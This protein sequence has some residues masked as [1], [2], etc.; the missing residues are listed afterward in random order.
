[1][2]GTVRS[3]RRRGAQRKRWEDNIKEW[4]EFNAAET[5]KLLRYQKNHE[6]ARHSSLTPMS[7]CRYRLHVYYTILIMDGVHASPVINNTSQRYT[8][9]NMMCLRLHTIQNHILR[10]TE[11]ITIKQLKAATNAINISFFGNI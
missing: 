10:S 3:E 9:F 7:W 2:L 5:E 4:T 6:V 11:Q 1:M 8:T